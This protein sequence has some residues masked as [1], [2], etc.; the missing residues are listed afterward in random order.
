WGTVRFLLGHRRLDQLLEGKPTV[1][2]KQ[3]RVMKQAL[4]RE[5]MTVAELAMVA[6]RQGF[7]SLDEIDHCV[8]EPGGIFAITV[9]PGTRIGS[10]ELMERMQA[11]QKQLEDLRRDLKL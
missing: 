8:L 11:I 3:G 9:K 2:I 5:M 4:A 6:H 7:S 1:L 10:S